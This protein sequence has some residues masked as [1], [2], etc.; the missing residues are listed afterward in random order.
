MEVHYGMVGDFAPGTGSA[1]NPY[2]CS[3]NLVYQR[4][5]YL[6]G[7]QGDTKEAC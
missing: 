2:P 7:Y 5:R 3:I 6:Y 1:R 4:Q